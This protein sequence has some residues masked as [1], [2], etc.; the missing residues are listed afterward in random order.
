MVGNILATVLDLAR[1]RDEQAD[2]DSAVWYAQ[3]VAVALALV[4]LVGI[5][6]VTSG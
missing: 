5:G 6:F 2:V 1:V 3:F 4:G